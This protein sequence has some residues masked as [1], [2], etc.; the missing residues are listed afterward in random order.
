MKACDKCRH[1]IP[2]PSGSFHE[3]TCDAVL[4]PYNSNPWP[5]TR[6]R[7]D[8]YQGFILPCGFAGK[9]WQA[10]DT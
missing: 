8:A 7:L 9:L 1:C 5:V 6:A 4:D 2:N 3:A 10:K